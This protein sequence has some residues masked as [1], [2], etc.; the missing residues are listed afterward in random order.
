MSIIPRLKKKKK[1][2]G[3]VTRTPMAGWA[4]EVAWGG[5]KSTGSESRDLG[6]HSLICIT[7]SQ[8]PSGCK[9]P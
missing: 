3:C 9:I 7:S 8:G 2:K 5:R 6:P 1:K 4:A